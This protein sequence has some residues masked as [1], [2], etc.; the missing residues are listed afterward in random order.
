MLPMLITKGSLV[1]TTVT[2]VIF[3]RGLELSSRP[4]AIKI[5]PAATTLEE[6]IAQVYS[7]YKARPVML[8]EQ[9]ATGTTIMPQIE[10]WRLFDLGGVP[11]VDVACSALMLGRGWA[12][13]IMQFQHALAYVAAAV[14]YHCK[15]LA[16]VYA[17]IALEIVRISSIQG[18]GDAPCISFGYQLEPY[19]ELDALLTATRRAYD[20]SRYLLWSVFGPN[21][22]G[23]PSNFKKTIPSCSKLPSELRETL[24][25]S[26][27]AYGER[28]TDYRDCIIHYAPINFGMGTASMQKL[29]GGVW[30]V[31]MRIPDNPEAKSQSAFTF[32]KGLDALSYGWELANEIVRVATAIMMAIPEARPEA[33]SLPLVVQLPPD[34]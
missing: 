13:P 32:A 33:A 3:E 16:D 12:L 7:R 23:I 4:N 6:M 1:G 30:S 31:L 9:V 29:E 17:A 21:K 14:V 2:T 28:L 22:G 15:R 8:K 10:S 11:N 25:N 26:W 24:E 19:F 20:A 18:H 27:Q 34:Q 5:H